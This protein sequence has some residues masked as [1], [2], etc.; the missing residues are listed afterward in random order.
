MKNVEHKLSRAAIVRRLGAIVA[1][2]VVA[3]AGLLAAP[4]AAS[5]AVQW[6]KA[7]C[8]AL[9]KY[10]SA[11]EEAGDA[12]RAASTDRAAYAA[13]LE[14]ALGGIA[15]GANGVVKALK[16]VGTPDVKNGAKVQKEGLSAYKQAHDV[17]ETGLT[18]LQG[19]D[20]ADP[21][22]NDW[23]FAAAGAVSDASDAPSEFHLN[24]LLSA[25]KKDKKFATAFTKACA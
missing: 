11:Y 4:A 8:N 3:L 16:R 17:A 1:A 9:E 12:A 13:V 5:T 21:T 7:Y 20:V 22:N 14:D 18:A 2:I 25:A 15:G 19:A 6:S 10:T 24:T 23:I